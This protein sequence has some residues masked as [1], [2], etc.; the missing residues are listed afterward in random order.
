M[1]QKK[2]LLRAA[3]KDKEQWEAL[4]S[5]IRGMLWAPMGGSATR[6]ERERHT[7]DIAAEVLLFVEEK[8]VNYDPSDGEPLPYLIGVAR[9][10]IEKEIP[11]DKK[12]YRERNV[13]IADDKRKGDAQT[14]DDLFSRL[15]HNDEQRR[16]EA[17]LELKRVLEIA[18][19]EGYRQI[20]ELYYLED[21]SHEMIAQQLG[22]SVGASK[23]RLYRARQYY[24]DKL[25]HVRAELD[26]R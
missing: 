16:V 17:K 13:L 7:L 2:N 5:A 6:E 8:E 23:V 18:A 26:Q 19:P 25:P 20:I 11:R 22:I 14:D 24:R 12:R 4:L 15:A 10:L 1:R 21:L 9:T 3:L